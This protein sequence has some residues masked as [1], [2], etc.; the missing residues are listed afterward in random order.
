MW[1]IT[2]NDKSVLLSTVTIYMK[3]GIEN[4]YELRKG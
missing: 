1:I 2:E 4:G 3:R